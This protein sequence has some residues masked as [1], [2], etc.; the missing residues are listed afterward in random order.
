[1]N[2]HVG[3]GVALI[4]LSLACATRPPSVMSFQEYAATRH[5]FP[6]VLR[7][8]GGAGSLL[9]YGVAHTNDPTDGQVAEIQR[10]WNEFRPTAAFNEG[11]APPVLETLEET[12]SRYG[13]SALVRW[14]ARRDNVPVQTFEP[15]REAVVSA[16]VPPFTPEQIKVANVL[17]GLS[18]D[19]RRAAAFRISDLDAEVD[20]VLGILSRVPGLEGEPRSAVAFGA[21]A[22]FLV[23]FGDWRRPDPSW[24]D[25]VTEPPPTWLNAFSKAENRLRDEVIMDTLAAKVRAGERVFAVIGGTH[26][27]MQ[28]RALRALLSK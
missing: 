5:T 6:Q 28:E 12:V 20:R 10:L 13:E 1:M 15:S 8:Q 4:A 16:L 19:G 3:V 11:G 21:R 17:R 27:V 2:A 25:P 9:Y 23:P 18:Q 14:L 24:F 22:S 26:V 7:A